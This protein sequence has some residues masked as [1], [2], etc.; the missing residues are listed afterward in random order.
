MGFAAAPLSHCFSGEVGQW[1]G[2][3]GLQLAWLSQ[4]RLNHWVHCKKRKYFTRSSY[5]DYLLFQT[6]LQS[7]LE[8]SVFCMKGMKMASHH[9]RD[10][11]DD[12]CR[13]FFLI[14]VFVKQQLTNKETVCE[15]FW[16]NVLSEGG[17]RRYQPCVSWVLIWKKGMVSLMV[18]QAAGDRT[19]AAGRHTSVHTHYTPGSSTLSVC[20]P[21]CLSCLTSFLSL[22][23][24]P[25]VWLGIL[26]ILSIEYYHVVEFSHLLL[27][28]K[29][30]D[31]FISLNSERSWLG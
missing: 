20:L 30:A 18:T 12:K 19:T 23:T 4:P 8:I 31:S 3:P 26:G 22:S 29:H 10:V 27:F 21:L 9:V 1:F 2:T 24:S 14:P 17:M 28:K 15:T 13:N 11:R 6:V 7:F 25:A 5:W 16:G